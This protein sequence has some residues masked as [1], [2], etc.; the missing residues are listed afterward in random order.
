M[1][2]QTGKPDFSD[3]QGTVSTATSNEKARADFSDVESQVTSTVD[4]AG[5]YIVAAGDN[6]SKIARHFYGNANAWKTIFDAN[7]D[8]LSDPDLIK[9]GQILKIPAKP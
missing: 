4:E 5:N 6:L 8:Q 1:A 7:R 3:V 9:P 2:N